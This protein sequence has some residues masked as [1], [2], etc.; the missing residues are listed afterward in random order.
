MPR[1][2]SLD[3]SDLQKLKK[4]LE[5]DPYLDK[6]LSEADLERIRNDKEANVIFARQDYLIKDGGALL[7]DS[8]KYYL[9]IH[10]VD[11]FFKLAEKKLKENVPSIQRVDAITEKK[12]IETIDEERAKAETGFGSI[13]GA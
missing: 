8:G 7:L 10:A 5:Y 12:I 1:V 4:L 2:Y 11:D 3:S 6:S 9:Y 13:F